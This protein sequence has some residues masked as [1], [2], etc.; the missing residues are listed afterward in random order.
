[1]TT[2][3]ARSFLE[4][5]LRRDPRP[6]DTLPKPFARSVANAIRAGV[7]LKDQSFDQFLPLDLSVISWQFWTP[8]AVVKRAAQWL[9]ACNVRTVVDIGSGAGKFCVAAA[10]AGRCNY[11]GLEQRPRLVTAARELAKLFEVEDRVSFVEG[12]FGEVR[13]PPA[14]AYYLFNPFGENIFPSD[15]H[16]D[17]DVELSDSRYLRDTAAA[18]DLLQ[19]A[20]RDTYLLT[21]NGFGGVVPST[22][23][24]I[25]VDR[26]LPNVL[27]MWR[28]TC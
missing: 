20:P 13:T 18:V 17:E 22:Y 12:K 9:D 4:H 24:E 5:D 6:A 21:Y 10:L 11:I 15:E 25:C 28:Q 7:A 8:L 16:L 3:N 14:D 19:Q 27:R 1:M 23:E 2:K 26:E